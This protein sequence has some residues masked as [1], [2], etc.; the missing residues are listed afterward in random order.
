M[1][2]VRE[3]IDA[4]TIETN[5]SITVLMEN[6]ALSLMSL[7]FSEMETSR[8]RETFEKHSKT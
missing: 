3:T 6:N 1:A 8:E 2:L 7:G 4:E 5:K